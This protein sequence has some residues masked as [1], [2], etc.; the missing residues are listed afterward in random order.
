VSTQKTVLINKNSFRAQ[1]VNLYEQ[2]HNTDI[3]DS[4]RE[5][6]DSSVASRHS[7]VWCVWW[8]EGGSI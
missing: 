1:Q 6:T 8:G 5:V 3:T 4:S 7:L 2:N